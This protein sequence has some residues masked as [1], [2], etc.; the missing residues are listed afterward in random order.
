M[1]TSFARWIRK[2]LLTPH[3]IEDCSGLGVY[4]KGDQI[5]ADVIGIALIGKIGVD[6]AIRMTDVTTFALRYYSDGGAQV[7]IEMIRQELRVSKKD[8]RYLLI[9]EGN[10]SSADLIATAIEATAHS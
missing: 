8:F 10:G 2:G 6:A 7:E 9:A 3:L 5:I 4:R 1:K